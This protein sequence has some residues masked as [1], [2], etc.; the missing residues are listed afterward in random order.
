MST[1]DNIEQFIDMYSGTAIG[2]EVRRMYEN[3]TDLESICEYADIEH[4]GEE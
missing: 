1:K 3:G 4:E 2:E